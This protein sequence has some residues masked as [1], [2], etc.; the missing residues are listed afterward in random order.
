[1][2]S[3]VTV[4]KTT[5]TI[6]QKTWVTLRI[7]SV[8]V[9]ILLLVQAAA[10]LYL[11]TVVSNAKQ[12]IQLAIQTD[13]EQLA[14][15]GSELAASSD[16]IAYMQANDLES[17]SKLVNEEGNSREIDD[18]I[19]TNAQGI[20]LVDSYDSSRVGENIYLTSPE[21]RE[22]AQ[23]R[24]AAF[25]GSSSYDSTQVIL[26]A[27]QLI[28]DNG[29][30]IGGIFV[31]QIA[32]HRYARTLQ[33]QYQSFSPEI[34]FYTQT[35]GISANT[36]NGRAIQALLLTYFHSS[37]DWISQ[38]KS[39][40]YIIVNGVL[41]ALTN[42]TF[43]QFDSSEQSGVGI[44]VFTPLSSLMIVD[45][46][47]SLTLLCSIIGIFVIQQ[48]RA[49]K[50]GAH[51]ALQSTI[52]VCVVVAIV[53]ITMLVSHYALKADIIPIRQSSYEIY[54][55]TLR[56]QPEVGVF[57]QSTQQTIR[58][59][60]DTGGEVINAVN[61]VINY[62][63]DLV[64]VSD[65]LMDHSVCTLIVQKIID[66]Q[67][68]KATVACGIPSPGFSGQ[69]GTIAELVVQPK[70]TGQY[71]LRYG[72][73][74]TVLANDGLGTDVLR[75]VTNGSYL[76]SHL[77]ASQ[78][79]A[80]DEIML[81]SSSHPN[82]ERWYHKKKV[83]MIWQD[84]PDNEYLYVFS[85]DPN[86]T[87]Y[88]PTTEHQVTVSA[89]SD[90]TY[91]FNIASSQNTELG[92]M[93]SYRVNIDTTAPQRVSIKAS[94]TNITAG[95]AVQFE[96]VADDATSGIQKNYYVSI[97]GKIFLPTTASVLIPFPDSGQYHVTVQVFDQAENRAR[98]SQ[99]I[100]V[101]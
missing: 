51:I 25:I 33:A 89:D 1:M 82:S 88:L 57:D 60:V 40:G 20:V 61:A 10:L 67:Q 101:D 17:L 5:N 12:H 6:H 8:A 46:I 35:D 19:V 49:K 44:L 76:T 71:G 91:Y 96:F 59:K 77:D 22:L 98:A 28:V 27:T 70:Q 54:N 39:G 38:G 83:K 48:Y 9:G 92:P 64:E 50:T 15:V 7:V 72:A 23:G 68:G 99:V 16:V 30:V 26:V 18:I 42:L 65:I 43:N 100:T 24:T 95:D 47:L 29:Q 87:P 4:S 45:Y 63:P 41:Y 90:G 93:S 37:S 80:A 85:Q 11:R 52:V 79:T 3:P 2:S 86:A 73:A 14:Q 62:N 84:I 78:S 94:A 31:N 75:K 34:L 58:L 56:L 53:G 55:A 13:L 32:D 74:S 69:G 81:Y 66:H 21:G 36:M 97:N